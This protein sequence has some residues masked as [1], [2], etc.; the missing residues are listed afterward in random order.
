MEYEFERANR[1]MQVYKE[2]VQRKG[3]EEECICAR[4]EVQGEKRP[5]ESARRRLKEGC[6][7]V[8]RNWQ[9]KKSKEGSNDCE[10]E[11]A[12]KGMQ[13]CKKCKEVRG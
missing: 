6:S 9:G 5:E 7:V 8:T 11:R 3:E 2:S 4:R 1:G 12:R 10:G 13:V